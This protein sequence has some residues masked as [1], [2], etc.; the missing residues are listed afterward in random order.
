MGLRLTRAVDSVLYGGK[1]MDPKSPETTFEHK[2]WIRRVRDHK[3]KQDCLL[4]VYSKDGCVEQLMT[5]G[6]DILEISPT[7]SIALVGIQEYWY[8]PDDL[9]EVCGRGDPSK[10][11]VVPQARILVEAPRSYEILRNNA[12]SKHKR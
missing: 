5:V 7:V 8:T 11:R 10:N 3:S 12:R 4:N 2:I 9:C 1:N 6:G